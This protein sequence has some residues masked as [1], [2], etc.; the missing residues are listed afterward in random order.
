MVLILQSGLL[1][2]LLLL[3]EAAGVMEMVREVLDQRV[4]TVVQVVEVAAAEQ[5][6]LLAV[7]V[8]LRLQL[9]AKETMVE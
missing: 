1:L 8:I 3:V 6:V 4:V 5:Q 9:Q 2:P 7:L